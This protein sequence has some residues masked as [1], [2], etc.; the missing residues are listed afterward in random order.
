LL[1]WPILPCQ[2][3]LDA[4]QFCVARTTIAGRGV[5]HSGARS[6]AWDAGEYK[7]W[8]WAERLRNMDA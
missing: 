6:K 4:A 3:K 1:G 8:Y 2:T 5:F 7:K